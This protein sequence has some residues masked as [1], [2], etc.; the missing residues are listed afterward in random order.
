MLA[1][2]ELTIKWPKRSKKGE[3]E[4]QVEGSLAPPPPPAPGAS[5]VTENP[6]EK[7]MQEKGL[8]VKDLSMSQPQ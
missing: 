4:S 7:E 8:A 3:Q 6:E 2:R 5:S 1:R